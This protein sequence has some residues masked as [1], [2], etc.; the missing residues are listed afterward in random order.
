MSGAREE[1]LETAAARGLL[2]LQ[3]D[4]SRD[5]QVFDPEQESGEEEVKGLLEELVHHGFPDDFHDELEEADDVL[6]EKL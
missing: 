4:A 3:R 1:E 6:G 5:S 2:G